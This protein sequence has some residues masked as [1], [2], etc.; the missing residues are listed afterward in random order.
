MSTDDAYVQAARVEISANISA[1]V[2]EVA[3]RD[4]QTVRVGQVLFKLDPR[5]FEIAVADAEA[6]LAVARLKISSLQAAYRRYQADEKAAESNVEYQQREFDRQAKLAANGISSRAQLDQVTQSSDLRANAWPRR[7][8]R[9]PAPSPIWAAI[10]PPR[11]TAIPASSRRR[12]RWTAPSSICPT[13][14]YTRRSTAS[15][16]RWSSYR[17]ATISTPPHRYSP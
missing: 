5:R 17:S 2:I 8:S 12:Q 9:P 10:R 16:P 7:P 13:R 3:V 15:L 11:S 1:R 14:W 6:Q 4:N